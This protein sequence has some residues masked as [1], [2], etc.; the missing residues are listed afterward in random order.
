MKYINTSWYCVVSVVFVKVVLRWNRIFFNSSFHTFVRLQQLKSFWDSGCFRALI[1]LSKD[2]L[3]SKDVCLLLLCSSFGCLCRSS[4]KLIKTHVAS[5]WLPSEFLSKS[6]WLLSFSGFWFC[7]GLPQSK[8]N[9]VTSKHVKHMQTLSKN[10]ILDTNSVMCLA[11]FNFVI[12]SLISAWQSPG[13]HTVIPL[14]FTSS[15]A[16][17]FDLSRCFWALGDK[18]TS[19]NIFRCNVTYLGQ[20]VT[21]VFPRFLVTWNCTCTA[22]WG[23]VETKW[24]FLKAGWK[25]TISYHFHSL[26]QP[27]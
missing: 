15:Q 11:S 6:L 5:E 3:V 1:G 16:N 24:G 23:E 2:R 4:S 12:S 9:K 26:P 13:Y 10:A 19:S 22:R 20:H 21:M 8:K 14:I 27:Y 18:A 25:F 7:R 17:S